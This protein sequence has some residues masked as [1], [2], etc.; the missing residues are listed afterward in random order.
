MRRIGGRPTERCRSEARRLVTSASRRVDVEPEGPARLRHAGAAH[1]AHEALDVGGVREHGV[2]QAQALLAQRLQRRIEAHDARRLRLRDQIIE[3]AEAALAH[4]LRDLVRGA[5][6]LDGAQASGVV[7]TRHQALRDDADEREREIDGGALALLLGHC[8]DQLGERT[9]GV[10]CVHDQ[11]HQLTTQ[12]GVQC[13]ARDLRRRQLAECDHVC[14]FVGRLAQRRCVAR[15][16]GADFALRDACAQIGVHGLRRIF[17]HH[18]VRRAARV[19]V[20]DQRCQRRRATRAGRTGDQQQAARVLGERRERDGQ[21]QIVER[22]I[23]PGDGAREQALYAQL[24]RHAQPKAA[25]GARQREADLGA[26]LG[27]QVRALLLA[28][29]RCSRS[30]RSP[31]RLWPARPASRSRHAGAPRAPCLRSRTIGSAP[32]LHRRQELV[33]RR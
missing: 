21:A 32:F 10:G 28:T 31:R 11:Q 8:A 17:D 14:A 15:G 29:A 1:A 3:L 23:G 16:V 2:R 22:A 20:L 33:D 7:R 30:A 24:P 12:R 25:A 27:Q 19:D 18:D 4:Q 9:P 13:A 5:E 6:H 26:A